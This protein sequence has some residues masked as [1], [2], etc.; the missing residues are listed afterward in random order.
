MR[1]PGR[2]HA[3]VTAI[4]QRIVAGVLKPGQRVAQRS[5]LVEE[6]AAPAATVQEAIGQLVTE[7]SLVTRKRA[8]TVVADHP[9]ELQRIAL[10]FTSRTDE[11]SRP[12]SLFHQA[13]RDAA[14]Q[15]MRERT[16]LTVICHVGC[17]ADLL[18]RLRSGA[19]AGVL[20]AAH[21]GYLGLPTIRSGVPIAGVAAADV[22]DPQFIC[23]APDNAALLELGISELIRAGHR[24]IALLATSGAID[25]ALGSSASSVDCGVILAHCR[26]LGAVMADHAVQFVDPN[27]PR[28]VIQVVRLLLAA[29]PRPQALLLMDDHLVAPVSKAL[30]GTGICWASHANRRNPQ[31]PG[32]HLGFDAQLL[33]ST[34]VDT[35]LAVRRGAPAPAIIRIPAVV[36]ADR[37][38][39]RSR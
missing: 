6:F 4:R 1:A 21:P 35:L 26:R 19:L 23:L 24:R 33:V 3:V 25:D 39:R 34:V 9:P 27:Q 7:G 29:R 32:L 37:M 5:A 38:P 2:I 15:L 8:G 20:A 13:L 17:D 30:A 22:A 28:S 14:A 10:L 31:G 12:V 36:L 16:G 18:A 11:R